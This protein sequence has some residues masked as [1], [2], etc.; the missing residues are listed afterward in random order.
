MKDDPLQSLLQPFESIFK[1][2]LG[3]Y[4]GDKA[5]I[6]IDP[7]VTLTFCK[8]RPLPYAMREMVEKE[9]QRLET[10]EIIKLVKSSKWAAPIVPVLK[11]D[12]KSIRICGDYKLTANK[13][14]K[15]EK[16]PLPK[17]EDLFSTLA[18]GIT[19]TKLDMSKAYQ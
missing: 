3:T 14:S 7:L 11:P 2:K 18:G 6:Y 10:L 8:A 9:L 19:F 12:R 16:Y 13:A 1:D 15:L 17:V 4:T 5:K